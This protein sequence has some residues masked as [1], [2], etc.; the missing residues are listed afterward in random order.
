[1]PQGGAATVA[2]F[3]GWTWNTPTQHDVNA[4]RPTVVVLCSPSGP[5]AREQ[6][7][8]ATWLLMIVCV[9]STTQY[10]I[11]VTPSVRRRQSGLGQ[12]NPWR[13]APLDPAGSPLR[14]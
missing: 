14:P 3:M 9:R 13:P 1:M 8:R 10:R 2:V 6:H 7:R 11:A 5:S 4:A 12:R